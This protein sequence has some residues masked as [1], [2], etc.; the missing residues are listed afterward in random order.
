MALAAKGPRESHKAGRARCSA[1]RVLGSCVRP[2]T[3][4]R[5]GGSAPGCAHHGWRIAAAY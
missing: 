4:G 2:L 3:R 1:Y 5:G